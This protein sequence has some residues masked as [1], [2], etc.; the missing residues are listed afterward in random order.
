MYTVVAYV[1]ITIIGP[2]VTI[3]TLSHNMTYLS[4]GVKYL[5][6]VKIPTVKQT[7]IARNVIKGIKCNLVYD[8]DS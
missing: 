6:S 4:T 7:G 1:S 8:F 3:Y 5:H 2:A